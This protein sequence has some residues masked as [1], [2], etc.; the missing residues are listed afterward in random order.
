M[1][2]KSFI[3]SLVLCLALTEGARAYNW[4]GSGTE[5]DPYLLSRSGDWAELAIYVNEGESFSGKHF[6]MTAD[7][8]CGGHMV[9]DMTGST[10]YPFSGTFDG[11][12]HWLHLYEGSGTDPKNEVTAPFRYLSGATIRHLNTDGEIFSRAEHHR[13]QGHYKRQNDKTT[14]VIYLMVPSENALETVILPKSVTEIGEN[15]F[16]EAFSL[17][18]IAVGRKTEKYT[19]DL[20]QD[21]KGIEELVFLTEK[22]ASSESDDPATGPANARSSESHPSSLGNGRVVTD[23][24]KPAPAAVKSLFRNDD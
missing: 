15:T 3:I 9:G 16:Q 22:H 7:F 17:K 2:K 12:G 19:R 13:Q 4:Q 14:F 1:T 23:E 24:G 21:L 11:D 6:R 10:V 5:D 18:R 8:S 20:L